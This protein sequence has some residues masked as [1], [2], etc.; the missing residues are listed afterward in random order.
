MA[1]TTQVLFCQAA[2]HMCVP[3][4]L[5]STTEPPDTLASQAT[6][7]VNAWLGQYTCISLYVGAKE[8]T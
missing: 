7:E 4:A 2:Q 3:A 8:G 1:T 6:Q 5:A